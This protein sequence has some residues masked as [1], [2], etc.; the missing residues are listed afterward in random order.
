MPQLSIARKGALLIALSLVTQVTFGAALLVVGRRAVDAHQ[1]ELHSQQV[2][3]GAHDTRFALIRAQSALRGFVVS[4]VASFRIS[5]DASAHAAAGNLTTLHALVADNPSQLR[6]VADM[7]RTAHEFLAYQQLNA[8]LVEA[9][10]QPDAAANIASHRGDR[11][12]LAFLTAMNRFLEEEGRLS[13]LRHARAASANRSAII[14]VIVGLA[15]NI[16]I[17]GVMTYA[18]FTGIK[19]RL[20]VLTENTRRFA[21]EQPLLDPLSKG[22]EI[23]VVDRSF[24]AMA[25]TLAR[26][27]EDLQHANREMEAFSYSVSHDLRT[28]LRAIDGFSRI[29]EEEYSGA[30]DDEGKRILGVI[31]RNTVTMAQLIDDLLT[32]S[33]LS[34]QPITRIQVDMNALARQAFAEASRVADSRN[35]EF[36]LHDLPPANGDAAMLRQVFA[37]LLSNAVKFSS[38]RAD[39]RIEVGSETVGSDTAYYVK[40]NGVGFDARF[41]DKLFGVFQRL[42]A[43]HEFEGTGVGLAIVQRVVQRHGGRVWGESQLGSGAT[44]HFTLSRNEGGAID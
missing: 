26:S 23:A 39:A 25:M 14:I 43:S 13:N 31:R 15:L 41:A 10:R 5:C 16:A 44:F 8:R 29:L 42:H 12:M 9:G 18:F 30:V 6:R 32:F 36:L 34:R 22:D 38:S 4:D 24:H 33:R 28:P 37:N 1:W 2:L 11:L 19:R 40:D 7:S 27:I 17:A 20:S 35:V 3:N 21:T